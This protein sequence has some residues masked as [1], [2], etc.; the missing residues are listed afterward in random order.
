MEPSGL[1]VNSP[2]VLTG[3]AAP[4]LKKPRNL[5]FIFLL[6]GLFAGSLYP[7]V[8][9]S[10]IF[11]SW[12]KLTTAP[13]WPAI[14]LGTDSFWT[15]EGNVYLVAKDGPVYAYSISGKTWS[16]VET[17]TIESRDCGEGVAL[18]FSSW[19]RLFDKPYQCTQVSGHGDVAPAPQF[20]F[21]LDQ[22]GTLWGWMDDGAITLLCV[23]P[24]FAAGGL[25]AGLVANFIW[26]SVRR[27]RLD[28]TLA[29][30]SV[31]RLAVRTQEYKIY[32]WVARIWSIFS[33]ALLMID[34]ARGSFGVFNQGTAIVGIV[35]LAVGW[36]APLPG[37]VI[38]LVTF[39]IRMIVEINTFGNIF[40]PPEFLG[41]RPYH[42][43]F[44]IIMEMLMFL[45]GVLLLLAWYAARKLRE[46][47][48]AGE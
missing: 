21:V 25:L 34:D 39:L 28:Q 48:E 7:L 20:I 3:P 33:L 9:A 27:I 37:G 42:S 15:N 2:P 5:L 41:I 46:E 26:L 45:P 44:S 8:R 1:P 31:E 6:L 43:T 40:V 18:R 12:E 35:G 16:E 47:K 38:V 36:I 14:L 10:G 23:L 32:R 13:A 19:K 30:N 29:P 17:F 11:D 4:R 24:F 22:K